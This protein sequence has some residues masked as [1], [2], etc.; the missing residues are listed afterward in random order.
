MFQIKEQDKALRKK[1]LM[2]CRW[3][4]YLIKKSKND[5]K[6]VHETQRR[7]EG[8]SENFNKIEKY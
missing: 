8:L 5:H 6:D 2:K 4:I 1:N 7:V 3:I